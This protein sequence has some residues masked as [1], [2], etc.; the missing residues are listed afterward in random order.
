MEGVDG[1]QVE[2]EGVDGGQREGA[3]EV[4]GEQLVVGEKD[5]SRG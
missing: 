5:M 1:G 4:D 3:V 2:G